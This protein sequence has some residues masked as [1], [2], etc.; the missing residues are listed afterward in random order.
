MSLAVSPVCFGWWSSVQRI[1]PALSTV[2]ALFSLVMARSISALVCPARVGWA[3]S[4]C[5][6]VIDCVCRCLHE[7]ANSIQILLFQSSPTFP[8]L[9][10]GCVAHTAPPTL[11]GVCH[12]HCT[13]DSH[14]GVSHTLHPR[15]SQGC[16]THTAPPTLTGVCHTHCTP[17]SHRGVPHTLH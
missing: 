15:L 3:S 17:D 16:A 8:R 10:Q 11:T 6:H 7:G 4:L 2:T 12:T 14:R 5:R 13:P 1:C 9:S